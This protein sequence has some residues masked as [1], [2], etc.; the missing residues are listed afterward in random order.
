MTSIEIQL[1]PLLARDAA[2][3]GLFAPDRLEAMFR[4]QL[5]VDDLQAFLREEEDLEELVMQEIQVD[6]DAVRADKRAA[7]CSTTRA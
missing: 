6:V 2:R 4:R 5:H 7:K 1:P 3:A